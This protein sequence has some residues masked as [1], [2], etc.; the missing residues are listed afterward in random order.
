MIIFPPPSSH[1]TAT[2]L[3]SSLMLLTLHIQSDGSWSHW[4]LF[5]CSS[6]IYGSFYSSHFCVFFISLIDFFPLCLLIGLLDLT[7][8]PL[9]F[10]AL[11]TRAGTGG[12]HESRSP[13][14]LS[15]LL[16]SNHLGYIRPS[17]IYFVFSSLYILQRTS[18]SNSV[19]PKGWELARVIPGPEITFY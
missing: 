12:H 14:E 11:T 18:E 1:F 8:N 13:R 5:C 6:L 3:A 17:T 4:S 16:L 19:F 10:T 15:I 2:K 9:W 7:I